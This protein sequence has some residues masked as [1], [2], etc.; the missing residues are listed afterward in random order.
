MV[1][2]VSQR[3]DV[4][5]HR[6]EQPL[7]IQRSEV[8]Q[9][10]RYLVGRIGVDLAAQ[11]LAGAG[12]V[13]LGRSAVVITRAALDQPGGFQAGDLAA[14]AGFVQPQAF[15]QIARLNAGCTGDLQDGVHGGGR[16]IALR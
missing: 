16:Q 1:V 9:R 13:E 5:R 4:L 8:A 14:G 10:V 2:V 7:L 12:Q 3:A 6:R 11:L 15:G